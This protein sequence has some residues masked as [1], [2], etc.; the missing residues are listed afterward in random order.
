MS[1]TKRLKRQAREDSE[2]GSRRQSKVKYIYRL[3]RERDVGESLEGKTVYVLWPDDGTWYKGH[4]E[5][6][7]V[8][9]E[10]ATIYYDE[11]E[12]REEGADL[13]ELIRDGQ[14]AFKEP[15]PA[16]HVCRKGEIEVG[17]KYFGRQPGEAELEDDLEEAPGASGSDLAD[18]GALDDSSDSDVSFSSAELSG[19]KRKRGPDEDSDEEVELEEFEKRE[20]MRDMSDDE[21]PLGW[22]ASELEQQQKK[23]A[24]AARR[25]EGGGGGGGG[26]SA[27][28]AAAPAAAAGTPRKAGAPAAA[29]PA[30]PAAAAV[31]QRPAQRPKRGASAGVS[32]ATRAVAVVTAAAAEDASSDD[33]PPSARKHRQRHAAAAADED[34]D[35]AAAYDILARA[36]GKAVPAARPGARGTA[37]FYGASGSGS[38]NLDRR[39]SMGQSEE[40]LR[41][42]VRAGFQQALQLVAGEAAGEGGQLP[43]AG[44]VAEAV[45]AALYAEHNGLTKDYKT[46]FRTLQFNLKDPHNPELRAHV[47][48]GDI[49]PDAFVRMTATE[50]ASKEL[51]EYRKKKEEEALKMSVLDAEAAARFSTAAALDARERLAIPASVMSD[52]GMLAAREATPEPAGPGGRSPSPR[53]PGTAALSPTAAAAAAAAGNSSLLNEQLSGRLETVGDEGGAGDASASGYLA[54][55]S[56]DAELA[57]GEEYDPETAFADEGPKTTAGA[58]GGAPAPA[59]TPTAAALDWASIKAAAAAAGH[60]GEGAGHALQPLKF[61]PLATVGAKHE[62]EQAEGQREHKHKRERTSASPRDTEVSDVG[63]S[64]PAEPG[65]PHSLRHLVLPPTDPACLFGKGV[66]EG[67]FGIPGVG[68]VL[69]TADALAGS[70]DVAGLLG[71]QELEVKGRLALHKLDH[72]LTELRHSRS[73]TVTLG[74]LSPAADCSPEERAALHELIATYADRGRIG[75]AA[76]SRD[77]EAYLLPPCTIA[78]RLLAA[79]RAA[80]G[81]QVEALLPGGG[82]AIGPDQ[83]L[84]CIIHRKDWRV[85]YGLTRPIRR[86]R[87]LPAPGAAAAAPPPAAGEPAGAAAEPLGAPTVSLPAGLDLSQLGALAAALGVAPAPTEQPAPAAAP[88]MQPPAAAAAPQADQLQ[89]LL[90]SLPPAAVA[91][92]AVQPQ[93]AEGGQR[94][95]RTQPA[96]TAKLA[97]Q[98]AT[99]SAVPAPSTTLP[100]TG[101]QARLDA[102][103]DAFDGA[104]DQLTDAEWAELEWEESLAAN[105]TANGTDASSAT[106]GEQGSADWR[107]IW[108]VVGVILGVAA[109]FGALVGGCHGAGFCEDACSSQ[110]CR[111]SGNSLG[112]CG[113]GGGGEGILGICLGLLALIVIA[114]VCVVAFFIGWGIGFALIS[115]L[116]L[117]CPLTRECQRRRDE[118]AAPPRLHDSYSAAK[119]AAAATAA[120]VQ[121]P[122]AK[123]TLSS[124]AGKPFGSASSQDNEV[125]AVNVTAEV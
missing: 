54:S 80:V 89:Q 20:I 62:G 86:P 83:L 116:G 49:T 98:A 16:S 21:K 30:A 39:A 4:V 121:L 57:G 67:Q 29:A 87:V 34:E 33:E 36:A 11:T 81:S 115:M 14:I 85:P 2:L 117:L 90:A 106:D 35:D 52:K 71:N 104:S 101:Q 75:V 114:A 15:R 95:S 61:E 31:A 40:E 69:L 59:A 103:A 78:E 7:D 24:A 97:A 6:C 72:F 44:P 91:P 88:A 9:A 93:P 10:K 122:S 13:E 27:K 47:L 99:P 12:E 5:E 37:S 46:R 84:L 124:D 120:G 92:G 8:A 109:G 3:L 23:A 55:E 110:D 51:A 77:V 100:Q 1:E 105:G 64:Q 82:T 119:Q 32:W 123:G 102:A 111:C 63:G 58:A 22:R 66:W 19:R 25:Q 43:E 42:K 56:A 76:P 79:A 73:R 60:E 65:S 26:G 45:E 41:S 18:A 74:V 17:S 70:G 48:R 28:K 50:L 53:P 108:M 38:G 125:P 68:A 118:L 113:G 112:A 107:F 94:R 96:S